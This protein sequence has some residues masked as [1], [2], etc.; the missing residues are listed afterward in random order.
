MDAA[1]KLFLFLNNKSLV[2]FE[3]KVLGLF[4]SLPK[5]PVEIVNFIVSFGPYLVLIGGVLSVLS[6]LSLFSIGTLVFYSF[7]PLTRSLFPFYYIYVIGSV[8]SGIMLILS[9]KDLQE[10]KLFGWRLVFWSGNVN[11]AASLLSMNFFGA[12]LSALISW[13]LLSQIKQKYS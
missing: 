7:A 10:K 8:I 1:K 5:L 12:I 9:F 3:E 4:K 6:I 11:I 2:A 13:Y